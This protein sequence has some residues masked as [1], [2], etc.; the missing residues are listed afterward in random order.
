MFA[1]P[2]FSKNKTVQEYYIAMKDHLGLPDFKMSDIKQQ[3]SPVTKLNVKADADLNNEQDT[4]EEEVVT[5]DVE[6][7]T[8][9]V[10]AVTTDVEAVTNKTNFVK[11]VLL[12]QKAE[13][14]A[15]IDTDSEETTDTTDVCDK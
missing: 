10:E 9:D 8:T 6:A 13:E 15:T 2:I 4:E 14:Y 7:V 11:T 5:T 3:P 12:A 1:T